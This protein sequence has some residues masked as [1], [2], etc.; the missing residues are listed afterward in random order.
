MRMNSKNVIVKCDVDA[1]KCDCDGGDVFHRR[2]SIRFMSQKV[3]FIEDLSCT[4][5]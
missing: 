3:I 4:F 5:L 2:K 1:W